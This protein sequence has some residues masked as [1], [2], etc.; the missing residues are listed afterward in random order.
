V[1]FPLFFFPYCHICN[2]KR[3][4][5]IPKLEFKTLRALGL[6]VLLV[7]IIVVVVQ[8]VRLEVYISKIN[9]KKERMQNKDTCFGVCC[10][11]CKTSFLT[12]IFFKVKLIHDG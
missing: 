1:V 12:R 6:L 4:T 7:I 8:A 3:D 11:M 2:R 5:E 10:Y 9:I